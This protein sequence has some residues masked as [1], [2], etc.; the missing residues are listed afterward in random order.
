MR[1]QF[2]SNT[3]DDFVPHITVA[4]LLPHAGGIGLP[5]HPLNI[6]FSFTNANVYLSKIT[7]EGSQYDH[8]AT[9]NLAG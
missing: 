5:D 8:V 1:Y 9:I 6:S 2:P 7:P 3:P 4:K